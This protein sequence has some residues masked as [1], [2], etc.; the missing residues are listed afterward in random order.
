[1]S[2]LGVGNDRL[3]IK[4]NL[5]STINAGSGDDKIFIKGSA[6]QNSTINLGE[7]NNELHVKGD[8]GIVNGGSVAD[9]VLVEGSTTNTVNLG[10]GNNELHIKGNAG[11]TVTTGS[12]S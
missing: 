11:N 9:T 10:A 12:G 6:S 7:G 2:D 3:D 1:M 8:V 5:G 4:G